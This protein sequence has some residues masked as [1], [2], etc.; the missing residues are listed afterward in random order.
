MATLTRTPR[1]RGTANNVRLH[2]RVSRAQAVMVTYAG[3]EGMLAE[4]KRREYRARRALVL[5]LE[6]MARAQ[7]Q[8]GR[9]LEEFDE[10]LSDVRGR[11]R[12]AG[13]LGA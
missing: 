4:S 7:A 13:Y 6:R 12:H 2:A 1:A 8:A 10:Y 5:S 3:R 11:L 9:R